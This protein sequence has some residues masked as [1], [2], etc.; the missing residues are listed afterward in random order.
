MF[1]E[2]KWITVPDDTIQYRALLGDTGQTD[3]GLVR[4]VRERA[5]LH[6]GLCNLL[7]HPS[8]EPDSDFWASVRPS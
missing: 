3:G 4:A 1:V 5:W 6:D 7:C 2:G 8:A